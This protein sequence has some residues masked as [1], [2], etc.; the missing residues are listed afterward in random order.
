MRKLRL[1]IAALLVAAAFGI[2]A[3]KAEA[4]CPIYQHCMVQYPEGYC[5]CEGFYC[6]G[7]FICGIPRD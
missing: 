3:P 5:L 1:P 4:A 6:D 7:R 2:A